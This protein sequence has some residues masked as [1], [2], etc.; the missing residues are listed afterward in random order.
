MVADTGQDAMDYHLSEP[1]FT[2]ATFPVGPLPGPTP[3]PGP[4]FPAPG[5]A[6]APTALRGPT[7]PRSLGS[8]TP[9]RPRTRSPKP[10]A[11]KP[12][13]SSCT[14]SAQRTLS[15]SPDASA[16]P[17]PSPTTPSLHTLLDTLHIIQEQLDG[18]RLT[19]YAAA[20]PEQGHQRHSRDPSEGPNRRR[21]SRSSRQRKPSSPPPAHI[22]PTS[23]SPS[24]PTYAEAVQLPPPSS[25]S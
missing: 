23:S 13:R 24:P 21:R 19:I 15:V 16:P 18:L 17:L 10:E 12:I 6:T 5:L 7:A 3:T 22:H 9:R 1:A 11:M 25:S 20:D 8:P 4:T 14:G 2:S